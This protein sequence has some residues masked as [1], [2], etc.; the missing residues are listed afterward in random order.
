LQKYLPELLRASED[1]SN[2]KVIQKLDAPLAKMHL[3]QF[4]YIAIEGNIGAGKTTLTTKIAED[5]NAKT[6]LERF[7][8]NPFAQILRRSSAVCFSAR[9]VF[10][11]RPLPTDRR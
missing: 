8:D 7:A 3:E 4:N 6:V 2:C 1:K 10:P 5:F 9:D 11:C